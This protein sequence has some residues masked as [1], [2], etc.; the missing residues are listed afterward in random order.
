MG[1][2]Y[3]VFQGALGGLV[4]FFFATLLVDASFSALK[5]IALFVAIGAA[6]YGAL[7]LLHRAVVG[8]NSANQNIVPNSLPF[9]VGA[10]FFLFA[11]IIA[12]GVNV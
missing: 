7:W 6:T 2:P 3:Q 1:T 8:T 12:V 9:K 4:A 10:G 11:S 5:T